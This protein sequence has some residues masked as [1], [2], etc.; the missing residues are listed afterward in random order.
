MLSWQHDLVD[1]LRL[2]N[3]F[4]TIN[5]ALGRY[6]TDEATSARLLD[7][8]G[9]DPYFQM[10]DGMLLP[11]PKPQPVSWALYGAF[12]P[13]L[14]ADRTYGLKQSPYFVLE[15]NGGPID[16][17]HVNFPAYDGQWRQA[18]W[19]FVSRGSQMVEYWQWR[20]I[21]FGTEEY[22]GGVL[23]HDDKPG[24]V[25]RQLQQLGSEF[26]RAGSRVT[27]LRPDSDVAMLYSVASRWA[28]SYTPHIPGKGGS[29]RNEDAF[30]ATFNAFY[31]GAFDSGHQVRVVYDTQLVAEGA[32]ESTTEGTVEGACATDSAAQPSVLWDA[33][34]FAR[35]FST[36]VAAG[37]YVCS[38]ALLQWLRDYVAAGGHLILGP[39]STYAD[40]LA[41]MRSATK[42]SLLADLAGAYYQEFSNL[43][44]SIAVCEAQGETLNTTSIETSSL[45]QLPDLPSEAK[46]EQWIDCLI[47]DNAQILAYCEHPHFKQFPLVTTRKTDLGRVTVV[48]TI[49]NRALAAW[50]YDVADA[51]AAEKGGDVTS[52]NV[53]QWH[54]AVRLLPT[55]RH[56]SAVNAQGERLHF[57][58]NFAWES[59]S[60]QLPYAC[61][62]LEGGSRIEQLELGAWDVQIVVE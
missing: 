12:A 31:Q 58:Y 55:V 3:Q 28:L 20:Q 57:F 60:V 14:Y 17:S 8:A 44:D 5:Y 27:D 42:P 45:P 49:P 26:E 29:N 33:R 56:T 32:A 50:V 47:A 6:A 23:P 61:A 48:G 30:D 34:E 25:Y 2:P 19:Q 59:C 62:T 41:G 1:E 13:Q 53:G 36:L 40:S 4:I 15:T 18:A 39:R 16:G 21:K 35:E 11:N 24:R 46:A 37:V 51:V 22:W 38:D 54:N 43:T 9:S 7:V 52:R 10:Q